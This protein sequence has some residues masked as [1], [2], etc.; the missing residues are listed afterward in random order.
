MMQ[1]VNCIE[2]EKERKKSV[3]A[4]GTGG[5]GADGKGREWNG[6]I[7]VE[8]ELRGGNLGEGKGIEGMGREARNPTRQWK[9]M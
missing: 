2:E 8:R 7:E 9:H 4:N 3:S 1:R 6:V 5:N